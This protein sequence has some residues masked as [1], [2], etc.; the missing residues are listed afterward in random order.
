MKIFA[1]IIFSIFTAI[2]LFAYGED[3]IVSSVPGGG[4]GNT[5]GAG[6]SSGCTP[7]SPLTTPKFAGVAN[8]GDNNVSVYTVNS[9]TGILT[10][11]AGSPFSTGTNPASVTVDRSGKFVY[12][13]NAGSNNISAFT[14]NTTTQGLDEITGSPFSSG[15]NPVS[16]TV[17][18]SGQFVYTANSTSKTVSIFKIKSTGE[19]TAVGTVSTGTNPAAVVITGTN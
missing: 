5:I 10:E 13:A 12:V 6:G 8:S 11:T 15:T 4:G 7:P 3:G 1:A 17:D 19:L 18:P 9:A 2:G 14:I 16:V